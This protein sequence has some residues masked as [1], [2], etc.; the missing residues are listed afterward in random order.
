MADRRPLVSVLT[1]NVISVTGS[2]FSL[3]AVPLF[4]LATTGSPSRM[5][6]VAFCEGVPL[7]FAALFGGPMI[8]RLGRRRVSIGADIAAAAAV[9]LIPLLHTLGVLHF[10]M[11]CVLVAVLGISAAPGDTARSVLIPHLA[12]RADVPLPKVT[13]YFESARQLARLLGAPLAGLMIA[14]FSPAAVLAAD[15]ASFLVSAALIAGGLRGMPAAEPLKDAPRIDLKVYG[16]ELREGFAFLRRTRLLLAIVLMVMLTNSLNSSWMSVLLPLHAERDL[17]GSV[18]IGLV[19]GVTGAAALAGA[20]LYGR[21]AT[22]FPRWLVYTAAFL[23]C[24]GPRMLVAALVPE[25]PPLLVVTAVAGFAA[26]VL[27]PLLGPIIFDLVPEELRSRVQSVTTAGV[28]SVIPLGVLS[29]GLLADA[30]GVTA[31][32]WTLGGIYLAVTLCP[33]VFPV[34]RRMDDPVPAKEEV[35]AA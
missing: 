12:K 27:N 6:L 18:D 34:W 14:V 35:L 1:A 9:G 5:G 7:V 11:L 21:F 13:S 10:W 8:D 22:R 15:A 20:L 17:G 3:V 33:L 25:L 2:S 16:S 26:G 30:A 23:I 31:A 29:A 19:S 32:L 28:M 24:G 4:V